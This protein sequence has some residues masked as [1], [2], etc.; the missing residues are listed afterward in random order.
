[1]G[2]TS[3]GRSLELLLLESA[4]NFS[5]ICA[6]NV[7]VF[8]AVL[9][10]H[11]VCHFAFQVPTVMCPKSPIVTYVP[12]H[13]AGNVTSHVPWGSASYIP[14]MRS[15]ERFR[16]P[17]KSPCLIR[18]NARVCCISYRKSSAKPWP[19]DRYS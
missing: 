19:T 14:D 6:S 18:A 4:F 2:S 10:M 13:I 17:N 15:P 11:S 5:K 16:N 1:M 8:V 9:I 3:L 12:R 7:D